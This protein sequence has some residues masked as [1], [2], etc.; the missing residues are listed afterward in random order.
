MSQVYKSARGKMV[1]MDRIRLA[2]EETIAVGNMKVNARGDKIGAGGEVVEGRNQIMDKVYAVEE[3]STGYSPN[4][5]NKFKKQQADIQQVKAKEIE[6]MSQNTTPAPVVEQTPTAPAP[7]VRGS[8]ASSVAKVTETKQQNL[9][10]PVD[11]TEPTGPT[12]I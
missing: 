2:N 5:P 7:K 12:R 11:P 4:D 3:S 9:E 10:A 1:D 6:R 8:L